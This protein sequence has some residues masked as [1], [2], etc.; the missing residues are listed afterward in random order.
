MCLCRGR[1][2]SDKS[3][4]SERLRENVIDIKKFVPT[5]TEARK[6]S[7][8]R[9]KLRL[10]EPFDWPIHNACQ[11][12]AFAS[13]LALSLAPVPFSQSKKKTNRSCWRGATPN[14][15]H[16]HQRRPRP[17]PR[18]NITLRS[19]LRLRLPRLGSEVSLRPFLL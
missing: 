13:S 11:K 4:I 14:T 7:I 15:K 2:T 8:S 6:L 16:Q 3:H 17:L 18:P 9:G 1:L 19:R 10:D 12:H 5:S